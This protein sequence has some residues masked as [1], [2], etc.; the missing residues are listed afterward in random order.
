MDKLIIN[1]FKRGA[2]GEKRGEEGVGR[3]KRGRERENTKRAVARN[4]SLT[5]EYE[6]AGEGKLISQRGVRAHFR[7]ALCSHG[8]KIVVS[9]NKK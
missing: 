6:L 2:G 1:K 7:D 5:V 3:E 4:A 9:A 8:K